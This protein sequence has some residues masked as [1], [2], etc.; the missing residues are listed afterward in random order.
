MPLPTKKILVTGLGVY[1]K[2]RVDCSL[3]KIHL[4]ISHDFSIPKE[5]FKSEVK[6]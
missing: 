2:F 5:V 3:F 6:K 1:K 4:N